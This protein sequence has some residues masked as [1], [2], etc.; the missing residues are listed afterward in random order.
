MQGRR[1][2][3]SQPTL[4]E[5]KAMICCRSTASWP[6]V[7]PVPPAPWL[8]GALAAGAARTGAAAG[9]S[10]CILQH[11]CPAPAP[12]CVQPQQVHLASGGVHLLARVRIDGRPQPQ[13]VCFV[14]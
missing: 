4:S 9:A 11:V 3:R 12:R 10:A 2:R 8:S 13:H 5:R 7:K 6:C 14:I 1:A